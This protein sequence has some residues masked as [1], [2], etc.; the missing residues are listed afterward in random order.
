[1]KIKSSHKAFLPRSLQNQIRGLRIGIVAAR[2][3]SELTDALLQHT[4]ET[5][6]R[7]GALSVK[8]FRVPGS[9]EI[10]V[11]AMRLARSRKYHV[12]IA[13]GVVLQGKTAHADHIAAASAI[14]LQRIAME[15]GI[16]VIHQVLTP[17]TLRDAKERIQLRGSEAAQAAMEMALIMRK[18]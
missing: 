16:P 10:T 2:Y 4:L 18:I 13:L 11:V 5:L 14:N 1:M 7:N 3:N 15:T 6:S 17:K 12:L 8:V 9:Y